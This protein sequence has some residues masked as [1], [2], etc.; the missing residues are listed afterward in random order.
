MYV[1]IKNN[2]RKNDMKFT[3]L[4]AAALA[5]VLML[6]SCGGT[7]EG[8][9]ADLPAEEAPTAIRDISSVELVSEMKVGWNLG[10]TL[11]A[12]GSR[13]LSSERSWGAPSI[14]DEMI[15]TV[16][17]A[18]F[19]VIRIPTTWFNH[20]DE[21]Q[22]IDPEWMARVKEIVDYAID[23]ETFVIL[24]VHH[25]DWNHT[26]ADNKDRAV[27]TEIK[28]WTQIAETFKN[29]DEHLIFEGQNEPRMVGT[30]MEW[31]E[32]NQDAYDVIN[33]VNAAFIETVRS[34]GGNNPKRHL[35]IPGYAAKYSDT[36]L[37]N[38]VIPENDDKIIV[39]VHAYTPYNFAL[40]KSGGKK[41][42]S[43]KASATRDIDDMVR[44]LKENLVDKGIAVIIG[45]TGAMDKD[46]LE[47]RVDWAQ[48][49]TKS[50]RSIGVPCV[51]WDNH[52]FT[53]GETFG[54]LKLTTLEWQYPEVLEAFV[55]GA[56]G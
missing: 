2:E 24:N 42:S 37:Q 45:E 55:N 25:E 47:S 22:N 34:S 40:N 17:A 8:T 26:F 23:G 12:T 53:S 18:G 7:P 6:S 48:Y 27:E 5:A 52:A 16:K 19:N 1:Y 28:V 30:D 29:Y 15:E 38:L 49:F 46:N 13:D 31:S 39:S 50:A 9:E 4:A 11:D 51:W 3:K 32:G 36:A 33:A 21:E 35:M 44:S 10:N 14:T 43:E 41:F 54:M 20:M 56:K